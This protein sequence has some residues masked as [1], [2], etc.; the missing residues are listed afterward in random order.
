[1]KK[2]QNQI[3]I[4]NM[5]NKMKE[6]E[7]IFNS[8]SFCSAKW[9]Q[10]TLYLQNGYNH[11]CHHPSPHKIPIEELRNNYKALHNTKFKISQ[12][13]L[14]LAG[15]KPEECSYCW[16]IENLNN[17]NI[18][19]RTY[20]TTDQIWSIPHLDKIK[21]NDYSIA[22]SYLEVSFENTCNLKCG[23]CSPEIS[24][25][26]LEEVKQYGPYPTSW[27]TGNLDWL[28]QT[29]RMPINKKD[30][31]PYV[32]AFWLWWP[33]LYKSLDTFRITG[34]E[35]LLSKNAWKIFDFIKENPK[36]NLNLAINSNLSV[37]NKLIDKLIF[38]INHINDKIKS[39]TLYTSAEAFGDQCDYIRYGMNYDKF[40]SN[41]E[42]VLKETN[43][44][45]NFMITFNILSVTTFTKFLDDIIYLRNK[46]N[47]NDQFNRIPIM[48]SYLRW[49]KFL[50]VRILDDHNKE[51]FAD[52]L[53]K[54]YNE[55]NRD[56]WRKRKQLAK[57]NKINF[58]E[59]GRFYL[60]EI[61][62]FNRLIGYMKQPHENTDL[63]RK[64][65]KKFIKEYDRRKKLNF[66][67]TFP[68]L[69]E[70]MA[71]INE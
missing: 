14:M 63:E 69:E 19:D 24:S 37:P 49:P 52:H 50:D 8:K 39:F 43:I 3:N 18:S 68:E 1:M 45:V 62:Q 17:N 33:E 41:I 57:E 20:K 10:T 2:T 67:K 28:K 44:N 36:E 27:K 59:N 58:S 61:D 64:N 11:S 54:Y 5:L 35:P 55:W 15:G 26:W 22:P 13:N 32:E 4:E 40:I 34:G 46:Y 47:I 30:Y 60:E 29:D 23:Y 48:V 38:N 31:N 42:K 21:P 16:N 25:K 70:F 56:A 51:I 65:F 9:L 71:S 53:E 12:R 6:I 7:H 66:G